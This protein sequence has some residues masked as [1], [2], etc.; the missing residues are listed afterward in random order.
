MKTTV[1]LPDHLLRE[2]KL[3]AA[4]EGTTLRAILTEALTRQ[5]GR[6]PATEQ[7]AWQAAYG[8]VRHLRRDLKS[9]NRRVDAAFG[10]VDP[11][12]WR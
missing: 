6:Q 12:D 4:Q 2:A 10:Q 7:P 3:R 11:D 8:G 9:V 5:L 1:E